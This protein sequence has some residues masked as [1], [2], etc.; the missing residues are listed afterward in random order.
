MRDGDRSR[1][2]YVLLLPA[3][4]NFSSDIKLLTRLV[5]VRSNFRLVIVWGLVYSFEL[6]LLQR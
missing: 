2:D 3:R 5:T 1:K 4:G 6:C